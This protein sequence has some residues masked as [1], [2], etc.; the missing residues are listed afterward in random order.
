V[1]L[2]DGVPVWLP[3]PVE[4]L[5]PVPVALDEPVP[6]RLPVPVALGDAVP[7]AGG[8]GAAEPVGELEGVGDMEACANPYSWPPLIIVT[9]G[10]DCKLAPGS[11]AGAY[12]LRPC[13]ER[14]MAVL[15]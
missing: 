10:P 9:S 7:V 4:L 1:A 2:N 13:S 5:G 14:P 15:K 8:V 11:I 3:V 6:V 12:A